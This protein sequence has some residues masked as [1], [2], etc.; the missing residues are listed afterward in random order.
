[1][2]DLIYKERRKE[3][4]FESLRMYDL[5]RWKKGVNRIDVMAGSPANLPYPSNKAIAPIP[6]S[7]VKLAGLTQNQDY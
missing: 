1:L 3:L 5:Q 4:A 2:L 7:D 6:L